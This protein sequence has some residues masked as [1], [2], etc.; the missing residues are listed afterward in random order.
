MTKEQRRRLWQ[1]VI[2]LTSRVE[3]AFQRAD[4]EPDPVRREFLHSEAMNASNSVS[5]IVWAA[6]DR[7]AAET[8]GRER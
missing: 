5:G 1:D 8:F 2:G 7:L 4:Q 6:L 3:A